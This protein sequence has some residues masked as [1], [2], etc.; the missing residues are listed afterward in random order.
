MGGADIPYVVDL[1][2]Q[3]NAV[4]VSDHVRACAVQGAHGRNRGTIGDSG[5]KWSRQVAVDLEPRQRTRRSDGAGQPRPGMQSGAEFF[6]DNS[7]FNHR[8]AGAAAF[9]WHEQSGSAKF[10]QPSPHRLGRSR[11][12]VE[13]RADML[14]A[15][16]A[17][18]ARK[19]RTVSRS[20]ICSSVNSR[21][22]SAG[23]PK[24]VG[25]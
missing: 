6:G 25:R 22:M 10:G 15:C 21:F 24:R 18:S 8:H 5:E 19:L 1:A 20:A 7:G 11:R 13:Q 17:L 3:R 2:A 14:G 23:A 12:V 16:E 9:R 4:A